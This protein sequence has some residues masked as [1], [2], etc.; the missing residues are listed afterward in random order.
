MSEP[1]KDAPRNAD[2]KVLE[3]GRM[4]PKDLYENVRRLSSELEELE[5]KA[6]LTPVRQGGAQ[7]PLPL[8]QRRLADWKK[9]RKEVGRGLASRLS[10]VRR[11]CAS[12][13]D[14]SVAAA[15]VLSDSDLI[16]AAES[17]FDAKFR[18]WTAARFGGE[19]DLRSTT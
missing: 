11:S 3:G 12:T 7:T 4:M 17:V 14:Y 1:Y 18:G 5:A 9:R 15:V 13:Q 16:D 2:A 19:C 6:G 10:A 8:V